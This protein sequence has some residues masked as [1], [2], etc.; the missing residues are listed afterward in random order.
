MDSLTQKPTIVV[1]PG[2]FSPP[3]LN[4]V[5]VSELTTHKYDVIVVDL[6]SV[7]GKTAAT[8]TDDAQAI[9][10]MTSKVADEDKDIILIMHS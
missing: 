3:Y 6:P 9:Q 8:M 1:V 4:N 5:F 10:A 2:S 7:G